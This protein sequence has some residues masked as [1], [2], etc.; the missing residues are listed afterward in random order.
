MSSH[1]GK[2]SSNTDKRNKHNMYSR[3]SIDRVRKS[4]R[5]REREREREIVVLRVCLFFFK[6]FSTF[7][8]VLLPVE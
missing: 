5:E 8:P 1:M 3:K 7:Y 6:C 2:K 4:G